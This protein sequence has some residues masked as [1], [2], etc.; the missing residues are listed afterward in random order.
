MSL[1]DEMM[2]FAKEHPD[3]DYDLDIQLTLTEYF[4]NNPNCST[5]QLAQFINDLITRIG[6]QFTND[7]ERKDV[8]TRIEEFNKTRNYEIIFSNISTSTLLYSKDKYDITDEVIH[9][10]NNKYGPATASAE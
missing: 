7:T 6:E 3:D 1:R 5:E 4:A 8:K 2:Q 10:L 9:F